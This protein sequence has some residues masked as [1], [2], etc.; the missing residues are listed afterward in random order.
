MI[1]NL[2]Y[3]YMQILIVIVPVIQIL[4]LLYYKNIKTKLFIYSCYFQVA[5]NIQWRQ[6]YSNQTDMYEEWYLVN[7]L[8][9]KYCIT[10]NE[11]HFVKHIIDRYLL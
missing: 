6:S 1:N 2:K 4:I 9:Y 10:Y 11:V 7:Y 3:F 5:L 8:I